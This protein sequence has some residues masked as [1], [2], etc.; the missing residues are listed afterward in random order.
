MNVIAQRLGLRDSRLIPGWF[1]SLRA[2]Q[3]RDQ[4]NF[5]VHLSFL[6]GI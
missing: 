4:S 6:N 2:L 1:R 5:D 3:F